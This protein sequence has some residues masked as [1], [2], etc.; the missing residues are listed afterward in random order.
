[1]S[2]TEKKDGQI[3]IGAVVRNSGE[4]FPGTSQPPYLARVVGSVIDKH[5]DSQQAVTWH[6]GFHWDVTNA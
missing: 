6:A 5:R 3:Q 2:V 1:M 4:L